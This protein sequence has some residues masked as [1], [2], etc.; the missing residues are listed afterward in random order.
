MSGRRNVE[1]RQ[2]GTVDFFPST[3]ASRLLDGD[4]KSTVDRQLDGDADIGEVERACK[5]ACWCVQD[6]E[7]ARPSMGTVV[8]AL[9]GLV[10]VSMPPVPRMLKVLGDPGN[11]VKF[12]SGLPST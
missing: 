6:E 9:E 2:D 12:F 1:Q 11:Y 5:V 7:G 3:A 4:V 10:D 8:Q